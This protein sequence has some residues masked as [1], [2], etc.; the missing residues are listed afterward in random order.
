VTDRRAA[1]RAL[2]GLV[3][4]LLLLAS[5]TGKES[6][7]P[8]AASPRPTGSATVSPSA[9]GPGGALVSELPTGCA[10][11]TPAPTA[12]VTF[13]TGGR[14]WAVSPDDAGSLT[15]LFE[16]G[17]SGAGLFSWGPRGDRVVL[18]G[19]QVRGVGAAAD[20]P[21]TDV[22]VSYYSWS[23]PT[24]TTV[25][26]TSSARDGLFRA[27]LGT[28]GRREITPVPAKKYGDMA[29]HPSG[30]AI[31][32]AVSDSSGSEIWMATNQGKNP[33]RLVQAPPGTTFPRLV[34]AHDGRG[35][36]YSVDTNDGPH[37]VVRYE[38][39]TGEAVSLWTGDASV[40]EIVELGGVPGLALTLGSKCEERRA[41]FTAHD[42][43]PDRALD[44]AVPGPVSVLGRLDADRFVVAAGGCGKAQDLYTV[45]LSGKPPTLLVRSVDTAALRVPEPTPAP[46][47]PANLPNA[48]FA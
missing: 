30:V 5:C 14:V 32:F 17:Q 23:R 21:S 13:V 47:L 28:S 33:Q 27:D 25:I 46:P 40:R 29:Y 24:G 34:F 19:L 39:E 18:S 1:P 31:G 22:R 36:Y 45:H 15:C 43:S 41:V 48:G 9:T 11:S 6:G 26:H 7:R 20:R 38:V 42:G 12:V 10:G 3:V 37:A 44:P 8:T 35:L 16:L 2:R 4:L